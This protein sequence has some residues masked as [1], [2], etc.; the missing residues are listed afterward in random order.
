MMPRIPE[1]TIDWNEHRRNYE[2]AGRERL[3]RAIRE[4]YGNLRRQFIGTQVGRLE[5][6]ARDAGWTVSDETIG[7]I[8]GFLPE[9][10]IDFLDGKVVV[11]ETGW[12]QIASGTV[13]LDLFL[14]GA[15]KEIAGELPLPIV[16]EDRDAQVDTVLVFRRASEQAA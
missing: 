16:R 15:L 6:L 2:Q 7:A 11:S 1:I 14:A 8:E 12:R 13:D 10:L 9:K 5:H 3:A 4:G